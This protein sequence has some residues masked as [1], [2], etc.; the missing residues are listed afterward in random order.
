[1]N[2]IN[3]V[4]EK[5]KDNKIDKGKMIKSQIKS[6]CIEWI[7]KNRKIEKIKKIKKI[8]EKFLY[9]IKSNQSNKTIKLK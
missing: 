1:L 2:Q 8:E 9:I 4:K 5:V 7:K 6:I 3:K